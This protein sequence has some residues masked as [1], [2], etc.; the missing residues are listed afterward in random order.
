MIELRTITEDNFMDCIRLNAGVAHE[1]WVDSVTFSLAEAWLYHEDSRPFAIYNDN[2]MVGFVSM[3]VGDRNHQIIN[4]LIDKAYQGQG[5]GTQ[6]AKVCIDYLCREYH[7]SRVSA[8]VDPENAIAQKF[9][10]RLGFAPSDTV[11][12]G[13]VFM[14]LNVESSHP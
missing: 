2:V 9:W 7:A 12:S 1:D 14:R 5:L 4:F 10:T 8:P 13:Y 3:Y 6:A 11:E